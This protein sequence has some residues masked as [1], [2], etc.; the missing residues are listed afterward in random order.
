MNARRVH[1]VLAAGIER[2]DLIAAWLDDPQRLRQHGM[3]PESVD[4]AALRKFAGLTL[5]VRHNGLRED[6]PLTFRLMSVAGLEIEV[7]T[8]YALFL[9]SRRSPCAPTAQTR[10][11]DLIAFLAQWLDRSRTDH[12]MLWDLVRHEEAMA[13]FAASAGAEPHESALRPTPTAASIPC[14][15]GE[16][17]LH[18]MCC[19]PRSVA[20]ALRQS[21]PPLEQVSLSEHR[22]CYWRPATGD[23][24][25]V[26][27]DAFGY[28]VL[29]LVDGRRSVADLSRALGAGR[30][31]GRPFLRLLSQLGAAGILQFQ[32]G[33][34]ARMR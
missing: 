6:W 7:F 20:A 1:A 22:F 26:E 3:D 11:H 18:E 25:M 24:R 14:I 4:L 23:V 5:K 33:P 16:V 10:A 12:S 19:D 34:R 15:R 17:I 30:R 13:R 28:Y 8:A 2:P 29:G 21:T 31:P 27:V 9:A 32:D